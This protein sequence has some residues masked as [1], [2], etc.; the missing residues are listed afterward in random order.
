M[1]LPGHPVATETRR[2]GR[3]D[4]PAVPDGYHSVTPWLVSRD[5]G[6]VIDF[7]VAAFGAH[8][9][10]QVVDET[11]YVGHAEIRIGDSVV[12]LFDARPG[13]PDTPAL[14]RLFVDDADTTLARAVAAGAD[15]VTPVT[16]LAFGDRVGR[17]RDPLGNI[18]WIQSHVEDVTWA[19]L[20]VRSEDPAAMAAMREVQD[21]LD[22]ELRRRVPPGSSV[23]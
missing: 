4:V 12:A 15:V 19:E 14:L 17:V 3:S 6:R 2:A 5:T 13:W 18:W 23:T 8:E 7:A 20:A 22:R 16:L 1:R 21:S 11:G 9:I 10:A